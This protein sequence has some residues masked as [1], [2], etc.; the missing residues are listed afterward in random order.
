MLLWHDLQFGWRS[1]ARTP[2]F[3]AVAVLSLAL[4]T[5]ANTAIFSLLDTLL[6]KALPVKHPEQLVILTNPSDSG[7]AIGSEG[8]ERGLLSYPEFLELHQQMRS[9]SGLFATQSGLAAY[10]GVI[11]GDQTED[12]YLRLVSGNFFSTLGV[13]PYIGRFFDASVDKE[14]GQAPYA[15]LSYDYWQRRFGHAQDILGKTIRV[16]RAILTVIGVAPPGF[17]GETVGANPDMWAPVTM[18]LAVMP[19]R[20]YLDPLPDPTEKV[21]WLHVFGRLQPG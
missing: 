8:G 2:G 7:L 4:G 20:D 17:F 5:G 13:Q 15:V 1:L 19:G 16:R 18:S 14:I 12:I 10:Q 6:M 21:M 9:L 3:F 11:R